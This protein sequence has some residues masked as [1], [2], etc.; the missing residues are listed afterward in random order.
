MIREERGVSSNE[1]PGGRTLPGEDFVARDLVSVGSVLGASAMVGDVKSSALEVGVGLGV[2][3]WS[4]VVLELA[5]L[6]ESLVLA[7]EMM[8]LPEW[9]V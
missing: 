1:P 6:T 7:L 3:F 5:G 2:A 4:R 8:V 9:T